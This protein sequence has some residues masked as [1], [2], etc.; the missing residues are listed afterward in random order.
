MRSI[1]KKD[2][3]LKKYQMQSISYLQTLMLKIVNVYLSIFLVIQ[4]I[5]NYLMFVYLMRQRKNQFMRH[6]KRL[7]KKKT[8]QIV[9]IALWGMTPIKPKYGVLAR[10]MPIMWRHGVR[11]VQQIQ[12]IAKCFA[13]PTIEQKA[14][15]RKANQMTSHKTLT[16]F[17]IQV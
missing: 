13:K 11:V 15:G 16:K 4:K 8:N 9:R 12:I 14:I 17:S 3:T 7:Q 6:K 1:T 10:W 2:I 5:Q